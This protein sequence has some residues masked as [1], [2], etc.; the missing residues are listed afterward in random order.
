MRIFTDLNLHGNTPLRVQPGL[1]EWGPAEVASTRKKKHARIL[2]ILAFI[3]IIAALFFLGH[4]AYAMV[5]N[6]GS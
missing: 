3:A 5:M 4:Y 1:G 6:S 2:W